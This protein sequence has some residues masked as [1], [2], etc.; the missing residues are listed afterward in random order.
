M[1]VLFPSYSSQHWTY[2]FFFNLYIVFC[3]LVTVIVYKSVLTLICQYIIKFK[4][5]TPGPVLFLSDAFSILSILSRWYLGAG[6]GVCDFLAVRQVTSSRRGHFAVLW[7]PDDSPG[8]VLCPGCSLGI[9]LSSA[10][11]YVY[12]RG[13]LVLPPD[14][15]WPGPM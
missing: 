6:T 10:V 8:A 5:L 13:G 14:P 11:A 12:Q 2:F 9:L 3:S 7:I 1:G 4:V 15:Q